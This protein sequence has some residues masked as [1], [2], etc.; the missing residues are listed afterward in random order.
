MFL[1]FSRILFLTSMESIV[2]WLVESFLFIEFFFLFLN[3][4]NKS[5]FFRFF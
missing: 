4:N 1:L 2:I 5:Q 3:K